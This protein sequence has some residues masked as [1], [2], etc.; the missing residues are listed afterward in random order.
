VVGVL[1]TYVGMVVLVSIQV[2]L[3]G[4]RCVAFLEVFSIN[5]MVVMASTIVVVGSAFTCVMLDELVW[6]EGGYYYLCNFC[7]GVIVLAWCGDFW[8]LYIWC[9]VLDVC[10]MYGV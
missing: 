7:V 4:M 6:G 9:P 3:M 2:Y 5:L 10:C 1:L 8:M